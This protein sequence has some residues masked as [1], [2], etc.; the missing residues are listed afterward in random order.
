MENIMHGIS[1]AF[2]GSYKDPVSTIIPQV[3]LIEAEI[4][5][6][7]VFDSETLI[8]N[9][10]INILESMTTESCIDEFMKFIEIQVEQNSKKI[11]ELNAALDFN[12]KSL[13]KKEIELNSKKEECEKLLQEE[14]NL[15]QINSK[16]IS[17]L[18]NK[19]EQINKTHV[20]EINSLENLIK[21]NCVLEKSDKKESLSSKDIIETYCSKYT[22]MQ[23][24]INLLKNIS[25]TGLGKIEE[26]NVYDFIK[27]NNLKKKNNLK[28]LIEKTCDVLIMDIGEKKACD[29]ELEEYKTKNENLT[30]QKDLLIDMLS[31][32]EGLELFNKPIGKIVSTHLNEN[33]S[34]IDSKKLHESL[35]ANYGIYG[36]SDA[37]QH[38]FYADL[39]SVLKTITN[40]EKV[41]TEAVTIE[42]KSY[43]KLIEKKDLEIKNIQESIKRIGDFDFSLDSLQDS[44][45]EKYNILNL[46]AL[47]E[48]SLNSCKSIL[49]N[50]LFLLKIP[51]VNMED[52]WLKMQK[53]DAI[54]TVE[55]V[56]FLRFIKLLQK[57]IS[58]NTEIDYEKQINYIIE[59]KPEKYRLDEFLM[60]IHNSLENLVQENESS[61]SNEEEENVYENEENYNNYGYS[62]NFNNSSEL[63][64]IG[65]GE[66]NTNVGKLNNGRIIS[67]NDDITDDVYKLQYRESSN[68]HAYPSR[69]PSQYQQK[70]YGR[71][72]RVISTDQIP[73]NYLT[74]DRYS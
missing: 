62:N 3:N 8:D 28:E 54:I 43:Q 49:K 25:T 48:I 56:S 59:G 14:E 69:D 42:K 12:N 4:K 34:K 63:N 39:S 45:H 16:D 22:E 65:N 13:K 44:Y 64:R 36:F 10:K 51:F 38:K 23:V 37:T 5:K 53:L 67:K 68:Q 72:H 66:V 2:A 47:D 57:L 50:C 27:N 26:K 46:S 9:E 61:L 1:K 52:L 73:I 15:K 20:D 32:M 18:K 55:R 19:Y 58:D 6:E 41:L 31:Q 60:F 74:N 33:K 35:K 11:T 21:K 17:E 29:N 7:N 24:F 40:K 30:T 71:Q 70:E